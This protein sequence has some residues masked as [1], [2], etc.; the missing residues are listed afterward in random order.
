MNDQGAD[1]V[2]INIDFARL[3][4]TML[5]LSAKEEGGKPEPDR[6]ANQAPTC[7]IQ[8][9]MLMPNRWIYLPPILFRIAIDLK[10]NNSVMLAIHRR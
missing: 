3:C 10:M 8:S 7:F 5:A 9:L 6:S 4:S 1:L 2:T